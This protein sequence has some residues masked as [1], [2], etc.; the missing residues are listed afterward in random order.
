MPLTQ[1]QERTARKQMLRATGQKITKPTYAWR[2]EPSVIAITEWVRRHAI[3]G[4]PAGEGY[5]WLHRNRA[6]GLSQTDRDNGGRPQLLR[7]E[8]RVC[9]VCKRLLLG[10]LAKHRRMLNES[11]LAGEQAPCGPDCYPTRDRR[12]R[13]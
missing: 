2:V 4:F 5:V 1:H 7:T 8:Y 3:K 11:I 6:W 10:V 9:K 12:R 13:A